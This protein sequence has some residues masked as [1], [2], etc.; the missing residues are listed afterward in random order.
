MKIGDLVKYRLNDDDRPG[1]I[2]GFDDDGE[3]WWQ[4]RRPEL[5]DG[6]IPKA[7]TWRE[8]LRLAAAHGLD[9]I[10]TIWRWLVL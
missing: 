4:G 1:I 5:D 10:R 8:R 6:A 9:L 7:L 2:M 3:G